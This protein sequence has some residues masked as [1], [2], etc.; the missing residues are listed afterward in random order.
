[1][2]GFLASDISADLSMILDGFSQDERIVPSALDIFKLS[3]LMPIVSLLLSFISLSLVYFSG[4]KPALNLNG[5]MEYFLSD[6]WVF[7]APT[8]VVG[9][10][11]MLMAYNNMTLYLTIPEETR[12]RSLVIEHLKKLAYRI[13]IFFA[14]LMLISTFLSCYSTWFAFGV[15][16]LE[17]AL[18]FAVN[19]VVGV[20]INRLGAGLVIEKISNLIKKI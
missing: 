19:M 11:F 1:M 17:F 14:T 2:K 10:V 8:I 13:V 15:P 3:A 5:F 20:E 6:G 4:Y 16:A 18:L 12:A 7:L 9:M